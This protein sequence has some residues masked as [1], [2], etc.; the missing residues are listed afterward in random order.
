MEERIVARATKLITRKMGLD[1]HEEK[2][3]VTGCVGLKLRVLPGLNYVVA[4]LKVTTHVQVML[5]E[6]RTKRRKYSESEKAAIL[7]AAE[8]SSSQEVIASTR[9]RQGYETLRKHQLEKWSMPKVPKRMG[10]PT[11][12][13]F[14]CAVMD[15]LVYLKLA[16]AND[17]SRIEVVANVAYSYPVVKH[18][19][20][21]VQA[22][23]EFASSPVVAKLR[24]SNSWISTFLRNANFTRRRVTN[25]E[26]KIPSVPEVQLHMEVM[27]T[28]LDKF[29]LENSVN[30]DETGVNYGEQPKNQWVP[31]GIRRG[32]AALSDEKARFTAMLWGK[33]S[34]KMGAAFIIVKCSSK[35]Y[36]LRSTRVIHNLH[37]LPG[38]TEADGWKLLMWSRQLE[39][40]N[41]KKEVQ[42]VLCA[43]PY[44][45]NGEAIIT[46]QARA[47][48]DQ[49]G[50]VMWI[51]TQLGP[52]F[53]QAPEN[54]D[55][56]RCALIWDNCTSHLTANV[57]AALQQ[58]K[59]ASLPLPKNMTD[60]LQVMDLVV[61]APVKNG[62]RN[63][64][65]QSLFEYFQSWK[66][67][68]L[69]EATKPP[70]Q[71]VLPAYDPPAPTLASGLLCLFD[72][73]RSKFSTE[74]FQ[75]GLRRA[76]V[77]SCQ[78]KREDGSYL[79]YVRHSDYH[80]SGD[81]LG[82]AHEGTLATTVADA[83]MRADEEEGEEGS[84]S[85]PESDA[86]A[87]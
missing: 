16:D 48:M 36:D 17:P 76:F 50:L 65:I 68:R 5:S 81:I 23:P 43:R 25:T 61:N 31:A 58:W 53:E 59:I 73:M 56:H 13:A 69:Q 52:H 51:D 71:Q 85:E 35:K 78:S 70:D 7:H 75:A 67:R 82:T 1:S 8:A 86:E 41:K 12:D 19:A 34:G 22:R 2:Q 64:R 4:E 18:A 6:L 9:K 39:I 45:Q 46:L 55:G 21:Q 74:S 27:Q 28:Q 44:L 84:D 60:K 38:F 63:A 37:K 32:S 11:D 83:T 47:W 80:Q 57:L 30:A 15:E 3:C 24:F 77:S 87:E 40:V 10:R 29:T 20:K 54:A 72:V 49:A 26:K 62:I 42:Q 79:R 66:I 33:R 14:N